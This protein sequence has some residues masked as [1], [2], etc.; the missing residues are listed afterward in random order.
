VDAAAFHPEGRFLLAA[1]AA[2]AGPEPRLR[3]FDVTDDDQPVQT[4]AIP[5][6]HI[7]AIAIHPQGRLVAATDGQR[8]RTY[9]FDTATGGL[10][11]TSEIPLP[12]QGRNHLAWD[13]GGNFLY[14]TT[15]DNPLRIFA[16]DHEAGTLVEI[17]QLDGI[18]GAIAIVPRP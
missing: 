4:G 7:D 12:P 6:T 9:S 17:A 18:S 5:A 10:D 1:D 15:R 16:L 13:L 8:L 11:L 3:A 14:A 2:G